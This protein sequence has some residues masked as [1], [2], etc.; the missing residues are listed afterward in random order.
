M[1][2]WR[3][4]EKISLVSKKINEEILN[5][6]QEDKKYQTQYAAVNINGWVMW[7]DGLLRD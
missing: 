7:H 4:I 3:R 5:M 6:V 2:I 1:W